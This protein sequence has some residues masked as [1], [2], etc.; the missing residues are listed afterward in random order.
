MSRI[1]VD[2][3]LLAE[4]FRRGEERLGRQPDEAAVAIARRREGDLAAR[5]VARAGALPGAA[6]VRADIARLRRLLAWLG[7]ALIAAG[8]LGG[9]VAARASIA[10][11]EVNVLLAAA[12]LLLVPTL[13]LLAWLVVMLAGW[14]RRGSG[15]GSLA[16]GAVAGGLRWLG[17]RTLASAHASDVMAALA[18]ALS[19]AW[20]RWRLSAMTHAFWLAYSIAAGATL[21]VFFSVVQYDLRWGTTLL[22]D[23]TVVALV[24][25]LAAWPA[26]LGFMP[27]A[28]P[29]WI[30]AGREG[31]GSPAARA[32]WARFVLAMIAAWSIV[33]R[34][35]LALLSTAISALAGRRMTLPVSR[36]GY[37]RL[38]T[39]LAPPSPARTPEGPPV[40]EVSRR[41]RRRRRGNAAHIVAVRV[42]L[43]RDGDGLAQLVPGLELIDLGR[44][45]DRAGR[46]AAIESLSHLERPA[47]G[48]VA[49]CSMLRTP[50][51]GT[52]RFLDRLADAADAPLWLVVDEG[53]RLARRGGDLAARRADWQALAE[54]AGGDAVFIDIDAPDA[55]EL[56]RLH[57]GLAGA[58][59]SS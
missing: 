36:P 45:D 10:E 31:A 21:V 50:D 17:P 30:V 26:A 19:T 18:G 7:L 29:A 47:A 33:P 57:A 22:D 2:D 3:W 4:T 28:D 43:A 5:L 46:G 20:G 44:V 6:A 32:D 58:G 9:M 27:E 16:G 38:A 23:A 42:E 13:T 35:F 54:R 1:A 15:T 48:V 40:P 25:W 11:A 49:V 55:G 53:A 51:A 59:A 41:R 39:D 14:R 52:G 8:A 56:A 24:E 34:A 12:A 37:L